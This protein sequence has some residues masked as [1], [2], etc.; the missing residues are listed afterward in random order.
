MRLKRE[1]DEEVEK[2][3]AQKKEFEKKVKDLEEQIRMLQ[4]ESGDTV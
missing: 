3:E 4:S 2:R 1:K